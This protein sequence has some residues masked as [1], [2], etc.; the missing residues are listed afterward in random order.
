MKKITNALIIRLIAFLFFAIPFASSGSTPLSGTYTINPSGSGTSNYTSF[1]SAVTA[2]IDSGGISGPV[3]FNV[4]NGTYS[5]QIKIGSIP[6]VSSVNTITFQS[7]S[8]DSSKVIL[9][10]ASSTSSTSNYTIYLSKASYVSFKKITIRRTGS[11]TYAAVIMIDGNSK[12]DS[13]YHNRLIGLKNATGGSTQSVV[14]SA[15]ADDSGMAF[16]NNIVKGG[17][18]G[19]YLNGSNI[20]ALEYGTVVKG[21]I[22][23]SC[24]SGGIYLGYEE[25]PLIESNTITNVLYS[26]G[27][28]M[29]F[30]YIYDGAQIIKNKIYLTQGYGMYGMY[31]FNVG[32][33]KD[34]PVIAN[35]FISMKGSGCYGAIL[36]YYSTCQNYYYNNIDLT[37]TSASCYAVFLYSMTGSPN[38]IDNNI[39]G[40]GPL[41]YI[42]GALGKSNYNNLYP[43]SSSGIGYYGSTTCAKLSDWQKATKQDSKSLSVDPKYI[44][45]NDLHTPLSLKIYHKGTPISGITDDIDGN[46]RDPHTPDIGA[47]EF[48]LAALDA[49][50]SAI[51]TPYGNYCSG[52]QD[53][54]VTL[55]NGGTTIL[56]TDS[57]AWSVNGVAQPT[58]GWAGSLASSGKTLVKIGSYTFTA[59]NIYNLKVFSFSPDTGKDG[60]PGNDTAWQSNLQSGMSGTYTI[61]GAGADFG[62]FTAAISEL[63]SRGICGSV[64]FNVADSTYKEQ[65]AIGNIAGASPTSTITFQS[66]SGDS[67]KVILTYPSSNSAI[68]TN[69][70]LLLNGASD[71]VFNKITIQRTGSGTY[72]AVIQVYGNSHNNSL[73]RN[74][75]I[76]EKLVTAG[77]GSNTQAII[78]SAQDNDSNNN[79][80][81]NSFKYG[82]YY[83]Y[84]LGNAG[85][86]ESNNLIKDNLM[87]SALDE[88]IYTG[89]EYA[90]TLAGNYITNIISSSGYGFYLY[91][92]Y[93]SNFLK[94]QIYMSNGGIGILLYNFSSSSS[95]DSSLFANN[96]VSLGGS[97]SYGLYVYVSSPSYVNFYYNSVLL[98]VNNNNLSYAADYN[99]S[100]HNI[101]NVDNILDNRGKGFA[102]S[103]DTGTFGY[104]NYNDLYTN[105]SALGYY[106][107]NTASSLTGWQKASGMDANSRIID[108][109]FIGTKNLHLKVY[110]LNYGIPIASVLDDVDGDLRGRSHTEIGADAMTPVSLDAGIETIDSPSSFI[111]SGSQNIIVTLENFGTTDLTSVIIDWSV[112][113][114]L[115]TPYYWTGSL[116]YGNTIN[117]N[118][119]SYTFGKGS[120]YTIVA[121]TDSP[122][123]GIDGYNA[124]DTAYDNNIGTALSGTYTI[125]GPG[126]D[127]ANFTAAIADLNNNGIC[128]SVIFNVADSTYTEQVAINTIKNSSSTNTITFQSRSGDSSKVV[129]TYPSSSTSMANN[130]VLRLNGASYVTFSKITIKSTGTGSYGVPLEIIG[131][132]YNNTFSHNALIGETGSPSIYTQAVVSSTS[133]T[134]TANQFIQNLVKYGSYGF[135]WTLRGNYETDNVIKDNIIDSP[136]FI[137]IS[138]AYQDSITILNN[139]IS[140]IGSSS[141][142]GI[143]MSYFHNSAVLKNIIYMPDGE[144]GI[145]VITN[146]TGPVDT[147]YFANNMIYMGGSTC[148]GIYAYYTPGSILNF[149]YNSVLLGSNTGATSIAGNF[150]YT[151]AIAINNIFDNRGKGYAIGGYN[152]YLIN[153]D[154]NDLYTNGSYLGTFTGVSQADLSDWQSTT[155][156]DYHSLNSDAPFTSNSNL[157]LKTNAL[158]GALPLPTVTDDIDGTPRGS[159]PNMGANEFQPLSNDIG[160]AAIFSPNSIMCGDSSSTVSIVISNFGINNETAFPIY[161]SLN[162]NTPFSYSYSKTLSAGASD[163]VTFGSTVN[164]YSGGSFNL[165]AYTSLSSDQDRNNDTIISNINIIPASALSSKFDGYLCDTGS[166]K[167]VAKGMGNYLI[168]WYDSNASTAP[169]IATGDTFL[170]L[171]LPHQRHFMLCPL[172]RE[173]SIQGFRKLPE[174]LA[175]ITVMMGFILMR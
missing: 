151:S 134:D 78:Y 35:N 126:A 19:F 5:D 52:T 55:I 165:K 53:I 23:D 63:T 105:G 119:G 8:G 90:L 1:H 18:N 166:V 58:Y 44:S 25:A 109:P 85:S 116:A 135:F 92:T 74:R 38:F 157:R 29:S 173:F 124:N 93:A 146:N 77:S 142:T 100:G 98:D 14:L 57:I 96:M 17:D 71:I 80:I 36:N 153:S 114:S 94:N 101:N 42:S 70:T 31:G 155:S 48:V 64:I 104:S 172:P 136:Y 162:G 127:Y 40:D 47:D 61:G 160:V 148:Y 149:Y 122:N 22:I 9:T 83:M 6:G 82:D 169:V 3:V 16:L 33:A 121:Y 171:P 111:C 130:Y 159:A 10:S 20:S 39:V 73:T 11:G 65:I 24:Y 144:Y 88:G 133:G 89:N 131:G 2:L 139:K 66:K 84:W 154:Y 163:T 45:W 41:F 7:A 143:S 156:F 115:Q 112:N 37:S 118:I 81:Q 174:H 158:K 123:V 128:G 28:G 164:T 102:I 75:L 140:G 50:I 34:T 79:F 161:F 46:K 67:S 15:N 120:S 60:F 117:L 95:T 137:G 103:A 152:R 30:N 26:F 54:V 110:K 49:G 170:H 113:G 56:T 108:A 147:T 21:N 150:L 4:A 129:L 175:I 12:S 43:T 76:G 141:G 13:F 99:G 138:V 145:Y 72:G 167:L 51:D 97:S 168:S 87:D 68:N 125:G 62:S 107:S 59:P 106:E 32:H 27:Y 69:Y 132:S 91:G 86:N